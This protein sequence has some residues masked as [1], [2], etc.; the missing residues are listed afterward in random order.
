MTKLLNA[1]PTRGSGDNA[2]AVLYTEKTG[3]EE[4]N[5]KDFSQPTELKVAFDG[6][7]KRNWDLKKENTYG[8]VENM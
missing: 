1:L 3:V 5:H 8:N 4:G 6:A 7:K 2:R